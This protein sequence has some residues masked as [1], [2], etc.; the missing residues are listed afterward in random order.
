MK[1]YYVLSI[2]LI[3]LTTLPLLT[4]Q[5]FCPLESLSTC[6]SWAH[7][8]MQDLGCSPDQATFNISIEDLYLAQGC[9]IKDI[10]WYD[11]ITNQTVKGA[12]VDR[13]RTDNFGCVLRY[14]PQSYYQNGGYFRTPQESLEGQLRNPQLSNCKYNGYSG[15]QDA[16]IILEPII[17]QVE[18]CT[19]ISSPQ[20]SE[21]NITQNPIIPTPA[22]ISSPNI[23]T[24]SPL[25]SQSNPITI[26]SLLLG[27]ILLIMLIVL[28]IVAMIK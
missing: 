21:S 20:P 28:L 25:S 5:S 2:I 10:H 19:C 24:P 6:R 18:S 12:T 23:E 4:A 3:F 11:L 14:T 1:R 9:R 17:A 16:S 22:Q 15:R 8:Q 7:T 13:Q 26:L 27:I